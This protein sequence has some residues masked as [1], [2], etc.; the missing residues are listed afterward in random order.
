MKSS[1][2]K[3]EDVVKEERKSPIVFVPDPSYVDADGNL[4]PTT[5]KVCASPQLYDK[6]VEVLEVLDGGLTEVKGVVPND[7]SK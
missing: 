7:G 1:D 3:A 2:N 4:I 6:V 5:V